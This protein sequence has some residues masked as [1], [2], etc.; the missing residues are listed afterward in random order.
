MRV[1]VLGVR[2]G[3]GRYAN[4]AVRDL[5]AAG[6]DVVALGPV[7][8]DEAGVPVLTGTPDLE[9]IDT[10][11]LYINPQRQGPLQD[12]LLSLNS[13]RIIFNPGTENPTLRAAA[14]QAGIETVEGCTLI[15]LR[16]GQF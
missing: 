5:V 7:E 2:P 12:Y 8:G 14:E 13:R 10:I 11:S 16:T 6:H 1:L 15:M 9:R 3:K 4:M